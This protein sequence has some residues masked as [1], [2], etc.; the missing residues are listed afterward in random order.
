MSKATA[1]LHYS[2]CST[3]INLKSLL[4]CFLCKLNSNWIKQLEN[5]PSHFIIHKLHSVVVIHR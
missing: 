5:E 4:P 1:D 2:M 3:A